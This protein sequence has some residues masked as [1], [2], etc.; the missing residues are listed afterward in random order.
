MRN[1]NN[2]YSGAGFTI[3]E[4]TVVIAIIGLLVSF[5]LVNFNSL[6][7]PRDLKKT[8]NQL[9]T[10][11]RKIQ[12]YTL[13]SK[14]VLATGD[15]ANYYIIKFS[16]ITPDRYTI[17]A[18]DNK[19]QYSNLQTVSFPKN[20]GISSLQVNLPSSKVPKTA[21]CAEVAFSLPFGRIFMDYYVGKHDDVLE[22]FDIEIG[23]QGNGKDKDKD[24][25]ESEDKNKNKNQNK[26]SDCNIADVLSTSGDLSENL[27]LVLSVYLSD[28]SNPNSAP[29]VV[30]ING[31][32]QAI[33]LSDIGSAAK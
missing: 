18:V 32:S 25:G 24:D 19:G 15:P 3:M 12:S 33:G 17:G 6:S 7:G 8:Q 30:T 16:K 4:M 2:I 1:K 20:I 9:V 27:N 14:D 5:F 13:S 22:Q 21:T 29:Q 23:N 31:I 28:T 10:D 11:L 26:T